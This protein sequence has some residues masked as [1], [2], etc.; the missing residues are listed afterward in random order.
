[1]SGKKYGFFSAKHCKYLCDLA[2]FARI[3]SQHE[4]PLCVYKDVNGNEVTVTQVKNT[5]ELPDNFDDYVC[6]G[7]LGDWVKNT[8]YVANPNWLKDWLKQFS[9]QQKPAKV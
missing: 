2:K 3:G 9:Q 8:N 5:P 1:M 7:E 6:V 4:T